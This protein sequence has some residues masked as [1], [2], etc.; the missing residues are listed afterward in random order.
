VLGL[1]FA[2]YA[3]SA[4]AESGALKAIIPWEGGGKVWSVGPKSVLFMG[5]FEGIIYVET[6]DKALDEG[7]IVCPARQMLDADTKRTTGEGYCVI[8]V[9]PE[10]TV[11]AQWKCEGQ[12]GGCRGSF[13]LTDGTGRFKGIIG[14]GPLIV[15]TPLAI[16]ATDTASGSN[17]NVR[18]GLAIL[19]ELKYTIP[20]GN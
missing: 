15:R 9:S 10:E 19:P 7:F 8:T 2:G 14:G 13:T 12:V 6:E 1:V 18:S 20:D 4:A 11:F 17:I 5:A 3:C 16:L